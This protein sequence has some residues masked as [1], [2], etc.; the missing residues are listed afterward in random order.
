MAAGEPQVQ[1]R[2]VGVDEAAQLL[3]L[4]PATIRRYVA[5]RRIRFVRIGRRVLIPMEIINAILAE[6]LLPAHPRRP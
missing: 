3:G 2:A 5:E 1:P 4:R 6:G